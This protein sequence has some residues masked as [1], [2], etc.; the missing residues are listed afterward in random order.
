MLILSGNYFHND[1]VAQILQA[2]N[3]SI[4]KHQLKYLNLNTAFWDTKESS[5]QIC[6]L[7]AQAKS[8]WYV[9]IYEQQQHGRGLIRVK[10]VRKARQKD[11]N[12]VGFFKIMD[13][14]KQK[15]IC[16]EDTSK[17]LDVMVC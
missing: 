10:K 11:S 2:I 9:S 4:A 3:N 13:G 16:R 5:E 8:L 7:V 6:K 14:A 17:E 1:S 12:I 15:Q